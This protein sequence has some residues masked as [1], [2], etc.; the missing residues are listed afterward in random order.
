[1]KRISVLTTVLFAFAAGS[2][3]SASAQTFA[4]S[5]S[6]GEIS[7]GSFAKGTI[8]MSIPEGLHVNSN[9]PSSRYAI[10][11]TIKLSSSQAKIT[12]VS[13]PKGADKMFQF[14]DVPINVYEGRVLFTFRVRVPAGY[15]GKTIR[16]RAEIRYQPC[17]T[18]V[19]Y[20]PKNQE[21]TVTARVR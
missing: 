14:S 20:P 21:I 5:I 11:T 8:V 15:R 17:T 6:G 16:V 4:G 3:A 7:R 2:F 19:C 9:R 1:M 10:P 12:G 13:Y 18:E